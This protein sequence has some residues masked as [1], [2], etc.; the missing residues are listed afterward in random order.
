MGLFEKLRATRL[1]APATGAE[2]WTRG[3]S[4]RTLVKEGS[5]F[6]RKI[7][8]PWQKSGRAARGPFP[9]ARFR[10]NRSADDLENRRDHRVLVAPLRHRDREV[11]RIDIWELQVLEDDPAGW[12]GRYGPQG[13]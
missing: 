9:R 3:G 1:T 8:S 10:T 11:H 7:S 2:A 6:Q 5:F 12:L 4:E 13:T